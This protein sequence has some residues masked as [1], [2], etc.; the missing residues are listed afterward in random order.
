MPHFSR[1]SRCSGYFYDQRDDDGDGV[2][3]GIDECPGTNEGE[4]VDELGCA[5]YNIDEDLEGVLNEVDECPDTPSDETANEQGC[6]PSQIDTDEDTIPDYLDNC[7]ETA[8]TD[9]KDTD[10]DGIG[11]VCDPDPAI[12]VIIFELGETALPGTYVGEIIAV[13]KDGYPVDVPI[14][15]QQSCLFLKTLLLFLTES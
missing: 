7:P 8:N 6:S 10:G 15:S 12:A 1:K 14:D 13:D 11:D 9:Q 5:R 4:E 2:N 3:N